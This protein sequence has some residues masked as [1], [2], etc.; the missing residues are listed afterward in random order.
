VGHGVYIKRGGLVH[1]QS[2]NTGSWAFFIVPS[3]RSSLIKYLK[4]TRNGNMLYY[5]HPHDSGGRIK[6]QLGNELIAEDD[7]LDGKV[8]LPWSYCRNPSL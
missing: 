7:S 1:P 5:S 8:V 4:L 6:S 3:G 2:H